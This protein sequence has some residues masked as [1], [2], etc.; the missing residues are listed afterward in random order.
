MLFVLSA[1]GWVL[2]RTWLDTEFTTSPLLTPSLTW[3]RDPGRHLILSATQVNRDKVFGDLFRRLA[4][5]HGDG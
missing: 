5:H 4:G 1:T 2:D 3:S